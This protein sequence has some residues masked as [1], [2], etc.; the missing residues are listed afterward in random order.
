[1]E[2]VGRLQMSDVKIQRVLCEVEDERY[3]QERKWG[4]QNHSVEDYYTILA[5]EFGE[6]GRAICEFRLQKKGS[7]ADIRAELIQTA[8]VA[9]AMVESLDRN[10]R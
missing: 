4:Q 7:I 6:V 2:E 9:A 1:M 10:G 3:H 5:E 8:A